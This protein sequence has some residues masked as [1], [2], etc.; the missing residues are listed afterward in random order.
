[1]SYFIIKEYC[2]AFYKTRTANIKTLGSF[3]KR[4]KILTIQ[5]TNKESGFTLVELAIVMIIIG[6]L[7]GGIL[8]GQELIANAQ[9][10]ATVAQIKAIDGSMS[11]FDDKYSAVPGDMQNPNARLSNCNNNCA[12]AGN[13]DGRIAGDTDTVPAGVATEGGVAFIHLAAADLIS[14]IDTDNNN[15][16]NVQFGS[17]L[18]ESEIDGGYWIA[19]DNDGTVGGVPNARRGHYVTLTGQANNVG[20]GNGVNV[21]QAG[22]IDRKMDD[23]DPATGDVRAS[24][25]G[26]APCVQGGTYNEGTAQADCDVFIRIQG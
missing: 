18:L 2:G 10:T 6:L 13:G 3:H 15:T 26:A 17:A 16:A 4:R 9:T 24:G 12:T 20:G 7:I 21:T 5:H 22:Q 23:G 1:V 19:Y 11:T 14:G 25:G 8:K